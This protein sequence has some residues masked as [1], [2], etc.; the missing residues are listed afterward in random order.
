M[1]EFCMWQIKGGR[2]TPRM[3]YKASRKEE[4]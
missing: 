1:K 3:G 4:P 2:Y